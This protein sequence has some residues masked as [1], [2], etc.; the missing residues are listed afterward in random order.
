MH[1][2]KTDC[3]AYRKITQPNGRT[4]EKCFALLE[5]YCKNEECKFYKE[6]T[7]ACM[8]CNFT[9]CGGCAVDYKFQKPKA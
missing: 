8:D 4:E 2:V 3:F 5:L 9:N 1:K 6:Q 7:K